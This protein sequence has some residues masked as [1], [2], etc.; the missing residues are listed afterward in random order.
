VGFHKGPP[1]TAPE[2]VSDFDVYVAR[3]GLRLLLFSRP[4]L[5]AFGS[6]ASGELRKKLR[7]ENR[8]FN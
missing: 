2:L 3:R 8:I 6:R 7:G 4:R 5:Y 1:G